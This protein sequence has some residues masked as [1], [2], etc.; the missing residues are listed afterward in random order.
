MHSVHNSGSLRLYHNSPDPLA[1]ERSVRHQLLHSPLVP[2]DVL[3]L[4]ALPEVIEER[5]LMACFSFVLWSG[6]HRSSPIMLSVI[7][8]TPSSLSPS[9]PSLPS[10]SSPPPLLGELPTNKIARQDALKSLRKSIQNAWVEGH[11]VV[12]FTSLVPRPRFPPPGRAIMVWSIE[13]H[14]LRNIDW[15]TLI[16]EHG[17]KNINT[18]LKDIGNLSMNT[19]SQGEMMWKYRTSSKE[20]QQFYQI[21]VFCKISILSIIR[22]HKYLWNTPIIHL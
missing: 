2:P 7:A 5:M 1:R 16:E 6:S 19:V 22:H 15:K 11:V 17:L 21:H 4:L 3:P 12:H 9:S 20:S 14:R 13:K 18:Q 10:T 8:A